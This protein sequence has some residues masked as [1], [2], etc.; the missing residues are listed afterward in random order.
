MR[1]AGLWSGYCL[2]S[3]T[4]SW[5][6][7][8]PFSFWSLS[9][10]SNRF[11]LLPLKVKILNSR[12]SVATVKK[13]GT[14]LNLC[15]ICRETVLPVGQSVCE[16]CDK[17]QHE[18]LGL[19]FTIEEER[20]EERKKFKEEE[21]WQAERKLKGSG[22]LPIEDIAKASSL[23]PRTIWNRLR[24]F[25][26][27]L[28]TVTN[29]HKKWIKY[30]EFQKLNRQIKKRADWI[31]RENPRF[32]HSL[33]KAA[34]A[35]GFEKVVSLEEAVDIT[36]F[37]RRYIRQFISDRRIGY[38]ELLQTSL[39]ERA[40]ATAL[41]KPKGANTLK[42]ANYHEEYKR[43]ENHSP[44]VFVDL[45]SLLNPIHPKAKDS[46]KTLENQPRLDFSQAEKLSLDELLQLL[47]PKV[48]KG[49][50]KLTEEE[51]LLWARYAFAL[52]KGEN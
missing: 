6:L 26:D 45:K 34:K 41:Q 44:I 36:G 38:L 23:T 35:A 15:R 39:Y 17:K 4:T 46:L 50:A 43:L 11:E 21:R 42:P 8:H 24:S 37:S 31:C 51:R 18:K 47:P 19:P 2:A 33:K 49:I 3:K 13:T 20:I 52:L 1:Q 22:Y 30:R 28:K 7:K 14:K 25:R 16:P 5:L 40:K 12:L 29:S 48:V 10:Q 32:R 27:Y 9:F